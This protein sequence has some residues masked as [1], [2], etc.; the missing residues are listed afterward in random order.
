MG[1]TPVGEP[2]ENVFKFLIIRLEN[3]SLVSYIYHNVT[4]IYLNN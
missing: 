3:T 2:P 1:S 4:C